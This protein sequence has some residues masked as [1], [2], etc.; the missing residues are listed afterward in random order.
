MLFVPRSKEM[1]ESISVNA[2]GFAGSFLARDERE[3]ELIRQRGPLGILE[4]VGRRVGTG[5][6]SG[7]PRG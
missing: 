5:G 7:Q 1:Y 4:D 6:E 2:L 3:L